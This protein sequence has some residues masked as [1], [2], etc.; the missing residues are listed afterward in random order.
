MEIRTSDH[1]TTIHA[2]VSEGAKKRLD[3]VQ[4]TDRLA[5]TC[6]SCGA[7][8]VIE[9]D[10]ALEF[11]MRERH[12]WAHCEELDATLIGRAEEVVMYASPDEMV[13]RNRAAVATDPAEMRRRVDRIDCRLER[14]EDLQEFYDTHHN[15]FLP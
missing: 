15:V 11:Q 1:A 3:A 6:Q 8:Y 12:C 9:L 7:P 13:Y 10:D 14:I 4:Q 2:T 5:F